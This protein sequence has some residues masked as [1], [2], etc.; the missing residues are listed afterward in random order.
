[1]FSYP[2]G[3]IIYCHEIKKKIMTKKRDLRQDFLEKKVRFIE[4]VE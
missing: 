2:L 1:M 4:I 3:A